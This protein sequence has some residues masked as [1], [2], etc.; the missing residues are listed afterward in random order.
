M[1]MVKLMNFGIEGR[2][3]GKHKDERRGNIRKREEGGGDGKDR[4]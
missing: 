2:E 1:G 4:C 3:G